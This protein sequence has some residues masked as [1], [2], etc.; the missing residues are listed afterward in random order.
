[1]SVN[2]EW[3]NDYSIGIDEIDSQHKRFLSLLQETYSFKQRGTDNSRLKTLV[4]ELEKYLVFHTKS[5]EMLMI[6]YNYP[7]QEL[8]QEE[9]KQVITKVR[10]K[11][12]NLPENPED[13]T[14]LLIYLMKW[15]VNHTTYLDKELGVHIQQQRAQ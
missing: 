6:L 4:K 3:N 13:L 7:K 10:E 14:D 9:H 1:M 5:E 11:I 12:K 8:Q 2:F 15:F